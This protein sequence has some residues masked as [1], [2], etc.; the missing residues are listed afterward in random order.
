MF[1]PAENG[2]FA[3]DA[4]TFPTEQDIISENERR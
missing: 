3:G 1:L 4:L 2:D